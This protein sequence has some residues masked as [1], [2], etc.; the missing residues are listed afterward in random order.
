MDVEQ[1]E[2]LR[3]QALSADPL[4]ECIKDSPTQKKDPG[5]KSECRQKRP[6]K[7]EGERLAM[8][9]ADLVVSEEEE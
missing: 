6:G 1:Y 8:V 7:Q 4:A 5:G 9:L 2:C 3:S